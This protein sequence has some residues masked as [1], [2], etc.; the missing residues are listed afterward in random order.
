[1]NAW[2]GPTTEDEPFP[3]TV[4]RGGPLEEGDIITIKEFGH[5]KIDP[6]TGRPA[7]FRVVLEKAE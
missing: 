2:R 7:L 4:P 1:V 3:I 6:R 5:D